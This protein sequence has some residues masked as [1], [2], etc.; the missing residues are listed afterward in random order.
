MN[1]VPKLYNLIFIEYLINSSF[2][3]ICYTRY[4]EETEIIKNYLLGLLHSRSCSTRNYTLQYSTTYTKSQVNDNIFPLYKR[5]I[6]FAATNDKFFS[7]LTK[8]RN[9]MKYMV[10]K[11]THKYTKPHTKHLIS[12]QF[13]F[14][15]CKTR[16]VNFFIIQMRHVSPLVNTKAKNSKQWIWV[17]NCSKVFFTII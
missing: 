16:N 3:S 12:Y 2:M 15:T 8:K 7:Y 6:I 13:L 10:K 9:K 5:G 11:E 4:Y 17:C 1:L 14:A